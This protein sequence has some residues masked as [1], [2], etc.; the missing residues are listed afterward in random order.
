MEEGFDAEVFKILTNNAQVLPL[1]IL[2]S[3]KYK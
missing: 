3:L 2:P 1:L